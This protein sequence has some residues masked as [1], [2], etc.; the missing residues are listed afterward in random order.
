MSGYWNR[1]EDTQRA[2][3]SLN[4]ERYYRTGD[5]VSERPDG[6]Y[7]FLGRLDRQVKRRGFRIELGEIETALAGHADI[8]EAAAVA[9]ENEKMVSAIIAFVCTRSAGAVS[10]VEA[11]AHC[12]RTLPL[13]MVP[14]HIVFLNAIPKGTRG[15]MDYAA[16]GKIAEALD[17]PEADHTAANQVTT[18]RAATDHSDPKHAATNNG[19]QDCSPA[20][21][22]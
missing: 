1:P 4:G 5:R 12:A 10:L 21:H 19:D 2:F 11:K 6:S 16:L 20:I 22:R 14:D 3:V 15:K 8:L 9:V 17:H 13:Y 7:L 18:N